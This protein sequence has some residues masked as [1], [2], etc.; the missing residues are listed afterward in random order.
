MLYFILLG[1]LI[2]FKFFIAKKNKLEKTKQKKYVKI[3]NTSV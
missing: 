1:I 3:M 2:Y